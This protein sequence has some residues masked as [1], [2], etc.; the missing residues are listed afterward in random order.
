MNKQVNWLEVDEQIGKYY[1]AT[2]SAAKHEYL[3]KRHAVHL[4]PQWMRVQVRRRKWEHVR[5]WRKLSLSLSSQPTPKG[6]TKKEESL[7]NL[8][9]AQF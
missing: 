3:G 5:E 8:Q 9:L 4:G 2:R 6:I 7:S 1:W